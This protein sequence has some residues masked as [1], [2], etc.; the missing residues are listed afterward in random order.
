MAAEEEEEQ[1]GNC[2]LWDGEDSSMKYQRLEWHGDVSG[3][4]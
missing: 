2:M 4:T 1:I 3:I